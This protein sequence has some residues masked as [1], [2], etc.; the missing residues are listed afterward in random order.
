MFIDRQY[1]LTVGPTADCSRYFPQASPVPFGFQVPRHTLDQN[2]PELAPGK[3][4][5]LST[6]L[7]SIVL[8]MMDYKLYVLNS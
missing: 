8:T 4:R 1:Y 3:G 2:G 5:D 6:V 7:G